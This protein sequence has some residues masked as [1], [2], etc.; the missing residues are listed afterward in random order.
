[1]KME[2]LKW[3]NQMIEFN[4]TA[5]DN[6]FNASILLQEQ[7]DKMVK[8]SLEQA[9]WIP[10]QATKV[11][12]EWAAR[13]R[14]EQDRWKKMVDEGFDTMAAHFAEVNKSTIPKAAKIA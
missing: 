2:P 8:T 1:M 5:F 9:A 10:E 14:K 7:Q 4:K 3:A 6:I 12:T 13:Y 11:L